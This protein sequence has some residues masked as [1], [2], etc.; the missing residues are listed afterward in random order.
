MTT[1]IAEKFMMCMLTKVNI[2]A[3]VSVYRIGA[4]D[5]VLFEPWHLDAIDFPHSHRISRGPSYP[6]PRR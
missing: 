1:A 6:P 3:G 2:P 5:L 4:I